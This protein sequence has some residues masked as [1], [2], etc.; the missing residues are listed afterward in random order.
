MVKKSDVLFYEFYQEWME[1][2]KEGAI[3]EVTYDKY[4]LT[5]RQI[6]KLAPDLK[7]SKIDRRA[8]QALINSYA[9]THEKQ[10]TMDFHHQVKSAIEDAMDEGYLKI[11]PTR[12]IIIKGVVQRKH[13][14]K[15][16]TEYEVK[17]LMRTLHLDGEL[18]WD[19]F[20]M[21]LLKTGLRFSEGLGLTPADFDFR[22]QQIIV[23]K[24]W[25]YKKAPGFFQETKNPSSVRTVAID[26]QLATQFAN[27]IRDLPENEP[28]F[29]DRTRRT[30][31]DTA[32]HYLERKCIEAGV[33]VISVHGLRHTHASML[34]YAGV[35][36]A[37]IAKRLGHANMTTTQKTYLHIIQELDH[38]DNDKIMQ[39]LTRF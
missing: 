21:L 32:N 13:K 23:N 26:F 24:T 12:K 3:K 29:I 27:V 28:I 35:S 6:K 10:T 2:Y 11:D 5:Q 7:V 17:E 14:I 34:L 39:Y 16:L 9:A 30:H 4:Q 22:N 31:N 18:N 38:K 33:N 20:I 15:Y 37:S 1:L 36:L 19:Y 25:N 8:Y